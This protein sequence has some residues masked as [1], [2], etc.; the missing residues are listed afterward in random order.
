[1]S[2]TL[3]VLRAAL[4]NPRLALGHR[5]LFLL[6]HMRAN[7]SLF[8][9][10]VGSHPWVE[11]YYEMHIG[12]FSWKSLWRQKLRHFAEHRA[13]PGARFMFDK[14]LHDGHHVAPELLLRPGTRTIF[15]V[16]GPEQSVKSLVVLYRTHLPQLPEATV[17]G[18][19]DYYVQRLASLARTAATPGLRYFYLDAERLIEDTGA[20]VGALS[21]WLGLASPIPTRYDTFEQTGRG[22][23]G[24][25]SERLKSGEVSRAKSDYSAIELSPAQLQAI[26]TAYRDCRQRLLAGAEA[27][28][29][30]A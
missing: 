8:G 22:H 18:A 17:Q 12:Y 24:D 27:R 13:K 5:N 9:H 7:T 2:A 30:L 19:V 26:R 23:G 1:M 14:V 10:L 4:T 25:H 21:G 28:E 20:A 29:V 16:R 11:G 3:S 15:M 6:S